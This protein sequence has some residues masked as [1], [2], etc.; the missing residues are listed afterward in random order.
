MKVSV[1]LSLYPLQETYEK[2]IIEF[3]HGLH[4]YEDMEVFTNAMST[5]LVG[6]WKIVMNAL[7]IELE[8]IYTLINTASTVIKI[9]NRPLPVQD[10]FLQF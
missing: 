1:E 7:T 10:G 5:Y 9:I 6:E 2:E 8:K 4:E 3:I